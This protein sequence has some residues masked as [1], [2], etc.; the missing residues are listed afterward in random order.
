MSKKNTPPWYGEPAISHED[1]RTTGSQ[2]RRS[3][4]VRTRPD[5]PRMVDTHSKILSPFGPAEQLL[6]GSR[7][8]S[9][10]SFCMRFAADERPVPF[11]FEA[12]RVWCYA[13]CEVCYK[14]P[15]CRVAPIAASADKAISGKEECC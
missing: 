8:I 1:A 5:G 2:L 9:A 11:S 14:P 4:E 13:R 6:G 15:S 7:E 10:S 12:I 3:C